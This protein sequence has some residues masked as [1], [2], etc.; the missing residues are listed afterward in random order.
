MESGRDGIDPLGRVSSPIQFHDDEGAVIDQDSQHLKLLAI[1][2]Y[3]V[4]GLGGLFSLIPLIHV[5]MGIAMLM[6]V[7]GFSDQSGNP[8]PPFLGW[9][10]IGLGGLFIMIGLAFSIAVALSGR[11]IMQRTRYL[12]SFVLACVECMFVPFGTI[13]GVFSIIVLS[14]PSV[15]EQYKTG[16]MA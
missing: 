1:F 16:G 8:P 4:G 5:I 2:H 9:I 13:L 15:K 12:Y 10:F 11:F 14:R 6:P 7:A 3:V